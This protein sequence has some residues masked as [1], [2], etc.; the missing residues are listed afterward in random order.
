VTVT[1]G[2]G[3]DP[4]QYNRFAAERE[5]P[6]FDLAALVE[7]EAP[8]E[9][10]DLGCGDGRLTATLQRSLGAV[11]TLGVDRS[12]AMIERAR[13]HERAGL[14]FELGDIGTFERPDS[15]DVVFANASLQ[16]VPD[17]RSVLERWARSLRPR[18]QLAVQ[19]P[20]NADHP[21]HLVAAAVAAELMEDPPPDAVAE[22]VLPPEGYAAILDELGCER[23]QVRLQV[24]V[25]R[26][27]S[28]A[29]VVE[30]VK[31]T[32][33]TRFKAPMGEERWERFVAAYRARLLAELGECAPYTYFFKR[34]LLWGR[35]P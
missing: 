18:G 20:A 27:D 10:A 25:H 33:L 17:H 5:Q 24:Y 9:L 30:W 7:G 2:D 1:A 13:A 35:L 16:W 23:Q 28:T 31:G 14:R 8:A 21:A 22:N 3:W 11:S 19:V 29:D 26:L 4:D 12:P 15:F 34:I 6:F 32:T